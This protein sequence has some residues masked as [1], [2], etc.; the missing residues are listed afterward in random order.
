M[1][2]K[3][4]GRDLL[5]K[6]V[7]GLLIRFR[8]ILSRLLEAK[9]RLGEVMRDA[10]FS[11]AEVNYVTGGINNL[12]LQ[13]INT[14]STR[15]Q[16]RQEII[17]G[18]RLRI[19]EPLHVAS[20][21]FQLAGLARG[22]QQVAKLKKNYGKAIELLMELASLQH[23]FLVLD[24]VIK[25]TNRRVNALRH[26]IIPR[27]E[28]TL[29]YVATELDEYE[30]EEFYR[31]KKVREQKLKRCKAVIHYQTAQDTDSIFNDTD[32]DLF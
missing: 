8:V 17:G 10:A 26:I 31:L 24:R 9:S 16:S 30:R 27:L 21:P 14:A 1:D 4:K 22:G 11:L 3:M 19:Y 29:T 6:K 32:E 23:N 15:I 13:T 7:D 25:T 18:V 12:V 20:D 5:E 2:V 28:R